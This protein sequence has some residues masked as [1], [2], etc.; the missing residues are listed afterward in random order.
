[1]KR[2]KRTRRTGRNVSRTDAHHAEDGYAV[3]DV[4][5]ADLEACRRKASA[6]DVI[7]NRWG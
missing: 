6:L 5:Y 2:K 4:G 7:L 3:D 1:M